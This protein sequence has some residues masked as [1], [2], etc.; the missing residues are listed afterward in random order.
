MGER[1]IKSELGKEMSV[2]RR[3]H[4]LERLLG[5]GRGE[6]KLDLNLQDGQD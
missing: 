4:G 3:Y 2:L 6:I 5:G 1:K